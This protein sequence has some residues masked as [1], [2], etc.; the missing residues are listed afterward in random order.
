MSSLLKFGVTWMPAPISPIAGADST[1]VTRCPA[2]PRVWAAASPP[3]PQPITTMSSESGAF[4]P[5]KSFKV[6]GREATIN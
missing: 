4:R 2:C 6:Y 5:P 1:I 3:R